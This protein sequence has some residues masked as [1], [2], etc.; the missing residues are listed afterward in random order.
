MDPKIS[1]AS[2]HIIPQQLRK[3]ALPGS[4]SAKT[5]PHVSST[6]DTIDSLQKSGGKSFLNRISLRDAWEK[7]FIKIDSK[8]RRGF[9]EKALLLNESKN[10]IT[11]SMAAM[12]YI[13]IIGAVG[14]V[15]L[16]GVSLSE[17]HKS[18]S[19]VEF[20]DKVA[21]IGWGVQAGIQTSF[22]AL[23]LGKTAMKAAAG[24]GVAGGT[25]Q[26]GLG[27]K[28]VIEGKKTGDKE[29]IKLGLLDIGTGT[30]WALSSAFIPPPFGSAIF[31]SASL[32]KIGYMN[33]EKVKESIGKIAGKAERF[34]TKITNLF[35]NTESKTESKTANTPA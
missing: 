1:L 16:T 5:L 14:A 4:L 8:D 24:L 17:L 28:Q 12:P 27:I 11:Y 22:K 2:H 32:L 10:I 33:K 29:K 21:S 20:A 30:A 23:K 34:K 6:I 3:A 15:G 19:K 25:I 13:S 31:L 7:P 9:S 18:K 35:K 26:T